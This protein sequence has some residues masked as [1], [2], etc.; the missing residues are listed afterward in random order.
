MSQ[1][2][3]LVPNFTTVALKMWA[4]SPQN[5]EEM[6]FFGINFPLSENFGDPQ[7]KLN[8]GTQLQT[9]LYAMTP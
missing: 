3:T 1:V 5:R 9:F 7:K 2:R 4:Y 8:I 6:V